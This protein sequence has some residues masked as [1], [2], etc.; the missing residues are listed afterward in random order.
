MTTTRSAPGPSHRRRPAVF[1]RLSSTQI[2]YLVAL[3]VLIAGSILVATT[4]RSFFSP[5]NISAILTG[6]SVLGFIAIGQTLVILV[7]S[8]DLSVSYV[9][10]LASLIGAGVMA[11]QS[12]NVPAAVAL[13]LGSRR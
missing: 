2:V 7:G 1:A 11:N 13:A 8:L 9:T 5:G 3:L 4:G 6:T 10:S 12:G